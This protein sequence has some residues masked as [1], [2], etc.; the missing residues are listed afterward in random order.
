MAQLG[1]GDTEAAIRSLSRGL[2][3]SPE[4]PLLLSDLAHAYARAGKRAAGDARRSRAGRT[5]PRSRFPRREQ[6]AHVYGALGDLDRAF[7]LLEK[8]V[9]DRS[10]GAMWL[11][12]DPRYDALRQDPRFKQFLARL[13]LQG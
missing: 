11:R 5:R 1:R 7:P 10:P 12:V 9:S 13:Q 8:A 2:E 3:R 4:S 6:A